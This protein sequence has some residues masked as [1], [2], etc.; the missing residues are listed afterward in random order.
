MTKNVQHDDGARNGVTPDE[1]WQA[2]CDELIAALK[3]C[4][5]RNCGISRDV[6]L[7][8]DIIER[9]HSFGAVSVRHVARTIRREIP[10]MAAQSRE[11]EAARVRFWRERGVNPDLTPWPAKGGR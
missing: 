11:V 2:A 10:A 8:L 9:D 4:E 5:R 1:E 7:M 3:E 6:S